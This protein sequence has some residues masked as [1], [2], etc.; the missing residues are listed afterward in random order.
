MA[1]APDIR[2][3][4]LDTLLDESGWLWRPQPF[5]QRRAAWCE[6]LPELTEALL[7]LSDSELA[8]LSDSHNRLINWLSSF[9]PGL[10]V[11]LEQCELPAHNTIPLK[12]LGPHF[13]NAIPGRKLAQINSFAT[14]V[15]QIEHPL[16]EW[17]GGKGHLGRLLGANWGHA[18]TTLEYNAGLCDAG[19]V[20]AAKAHVTQRFFKV[21]V[22]SSDADQYLPRHHAV[23]LH[24][25]G[26]LHRQLISK[27]V[28]TRAPAIDLAPCC[29][30][31]GRDEDYQPFTAGLQLRLNRDE[32]RLA[33]T[34]TVT[35][36][37]RELKW[38]DQEMAWKLGYEQLRQ[39]LSGT[40]HY[41]NIKPIN[42]QWL[43]ANFETFCI[44]LA[45]R[46][47]VKLPATTDW[48]HYQNSGW[49]RHAEV[50]RLSLL[51]NAFRRPIEMW[52]I[53]DITNY[54]S[55]HGYRVELAEFCS[56]EQTPRNI[57]ISARMI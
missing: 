9:I 23:A 57:L 54:L 34:E 48:L 17:C 42:K 14:A 1:H 37:A 26:D 31:L 52:L 39:D 5:K 36:V 53:L 47:G 45:K 13:N 38:R 24:A 28:A 19:E 49:Q 16:V 33:V 27:A 41:Q 22:L 44:N 56:R 29:Y 21:D 7:Q 25:C 8:E 10:A 3:Q 18:V 55:Q 46:E 40:P 15:G 30:H 43:R 35:S 32:L 20:L 50:M 11:L 6:Q 4:Q 51:R 12:D 2:L